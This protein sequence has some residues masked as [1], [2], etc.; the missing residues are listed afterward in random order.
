[1]NTNSV[2]IESRAFV[3]EL[4]EKSSI[5]AKANFADKKKSR[6]KK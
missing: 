3:L 4:K 2:D 6:G 5:F 1:V